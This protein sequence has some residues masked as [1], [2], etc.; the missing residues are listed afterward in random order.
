MSRNSILLVQALWRAWLLEFIFHL[1]DS[2][3]RSASEGSP[4][5]YEWKERNKWFHCI[6]ESESNSTSL[7]ISLF[8]SSYCEDL[9]QGLCLKTGEIEMHAS[10]EA[11]MQKKQ[12]VCLLQMTFTAKGCSQSA[13][14]E[15]DLQCTRKPQANEGMFVVNVCLVRYC[16]VQE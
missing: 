13:A 7:H 14:W 9:P 11:T 4:R 5:S 6:R 10:T 12:T 8:H 2:H 3:V 16:L 15:K 1:L